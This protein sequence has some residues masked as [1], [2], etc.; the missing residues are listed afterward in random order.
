MTIAEPSHNDFK[1]LGL[2]FHESGDVLA[3]TLKTKDANKSLS[4]LQTTL[5][6]C[7]QCHATFRQ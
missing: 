1:L 4:A 3:N 2:A 5:G 6:Y 7:V